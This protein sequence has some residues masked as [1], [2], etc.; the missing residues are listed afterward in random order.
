MSVKPVALIDPKFTIKKME[1]DK[2][3]FGATSTLYKNILN[4]VKESIIPYSRR[5][6]YN[7]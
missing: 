2:I 3:I 1:Q 5:C 7:L 4:A 6:S